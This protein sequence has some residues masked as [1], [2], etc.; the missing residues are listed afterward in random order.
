MCTGNPVI[1]SSATSHLHH[2]PSLLSCQPARSITDHMQPHK[3][4]HRPTKCQ[5]LK[6]P[7]KLAQIYRCYLYSTACPVG[8]HYPDMSELL[9]S[10]ISNQMWGNTVSVSRPRT[11]LSNPF[12]FV[13]HLYHIIRNPTVW[14]AYQCHTYRSILIFSHTCCHD[15]VKEEVRNFGISMDI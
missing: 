14:N 4:F 11:F 2:T 8:T 5:F 10:N 13:I 9:F 1:T 12:L 6:W 15:I 7:S 3:T